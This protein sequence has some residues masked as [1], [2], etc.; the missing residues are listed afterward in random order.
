MLQPT[1]SQNRKRAR[2]NSLDLSVEGAVRKLIAPR[3]LGD[4]TNANRRN[5]ED[6]TIIPDD[7]VADSFLLRKENKHALKEANKRPTKAVKTTGLKE[8]GLPPSKKK[9]GS[10]GSDRGGR[11][12]VRTLH[13]LR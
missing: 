11:E 13:C 5:E 2:P 7:C 6:R 4:I 9:V 12:E 10:A 8:V 1:L 3:C